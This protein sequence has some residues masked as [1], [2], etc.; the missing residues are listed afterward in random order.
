MST[1][2]GLAQLKSMRGVGTAFDQLCIE[3]EISNVLENGR[4]RETG[5]ELPSVRSEPLLALLEDDIIAENIATDCNDPYHDPRSCPTCE[6]RTDGIDAYRA[7]LMNR[8][9]NAE[10]EVSK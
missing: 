3:R 9:A 8:L 7:E 6:A 2:N 5:T 4:T 1:I 10:S